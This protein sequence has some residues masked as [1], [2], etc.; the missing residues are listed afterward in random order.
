MPNIWAFHNMIRSNNLD[1]F[2]RFV[3]ADQTR[4][5]KTEEVQKMLMGYFN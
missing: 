2:S 3:I 1:C 5:V 4:S